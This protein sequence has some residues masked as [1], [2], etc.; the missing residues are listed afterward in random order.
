MGG[1]EQFS[2]PCCTFIAQGSGTCLYLL[3]EG[4]DEDVE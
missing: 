4:G 3:S 1:M 2:Y